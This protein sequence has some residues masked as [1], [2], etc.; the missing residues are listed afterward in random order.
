[1]K[2]PYSRPP[3]VG[4]GATPAAT[5]TALPISIPRREQGDSTNLEINLQL[6]TK[7]RTEVSLTY[8]TESPAWKPTYRVAVGDRAR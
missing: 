5:N 2:A 7:A 3:P 8:V 6:P 4:N 1:M